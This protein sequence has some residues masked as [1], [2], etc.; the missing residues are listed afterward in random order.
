MRIEACNRPRRVR[1]IRGPLDC[2]TCRELE[3]IQPGMRR[4]FAELARAF[5]LSGK[6]RRLSNRADECE[7]YH[8]HARVRIVPIDAANC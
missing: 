1:N 5:A 7:V 8:T 2:T 4:A 3:D 6:A